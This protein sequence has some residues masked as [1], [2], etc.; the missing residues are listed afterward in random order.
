M[1]EAFSHGPFPEDSGE[2]L[3]NAETSETFM[4]RLPGNSF[5]RFTPWK[6]MAFVLAGLAWALATRPARA[7]SFVIDPDQSSIT[8]YLQVTVDGNIV[9]L[10]PQSPGSLRAAIQGTFDLNLATP[11]FIS[12]LASMTPRP[13]TALAEPYAE[14]ADFAGQLAGVPVSSQSIL[15]A[16]RDSQLVASIPVG[17][18]IDPLGQFSVL[19][20]FASFPQGT[21]DV[22]IPGLGETSLALSVLNLSASNQATELGQIELLSD[23]RRKLTVPVYSRYRLSFLGLPAT[24]GLEGSIVAYT[25]VPELPSHHLALAALFALACCGY[26]GRRP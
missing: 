15:M 8:V 23:G 4:N 7:E 2:R 13:S 20:I 22:Q 5:V 25:T 19:G 16:I 9:L 11:G 1:N 10:E 18:G 12:G 21:L 24:S 17:T 26:R 6:S 14:P 3:R